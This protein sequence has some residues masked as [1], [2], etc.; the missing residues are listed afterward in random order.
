ME[1]AKK[2]I[3]LSDIDVYFLK[4][5]ETKL[6]W[7]FD[8]NDSGIWEKRENFYNGIRKPERHV[9][10]IDI[11]RPWFYNLFKPKI[12]GEPRSDIYATT[13]YLNCNLRQFNE[14][15]KA[16]YFAKFE[17]ELCLTDAEEQNVTLKK[18]NND[19]ANSIRFL[20]SRINTLESEL[21]ELRAKETIKAQADKKGIQ[22]SGQ[23]SLQDAQEVLFGKRQEK[24][25]EPEPDI[26]EDPEEPLDKFEEKIEEPIT[27]WKAM[28]FAETS[29][30][31]KKLEFVDSQFKTLLV[32][33]TTREIPAERFLDY[34]KQ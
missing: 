7:D 19:Q 31:K 33:I 17:E 8:S 2:K 30:L 1:E 21:E 9:L 29:E 27:N 32:L 25:L 5:E 11:T 28:Y 26:E 3:E 13:L 4:P 20:Q 10:A 15:I 6:L 24:I 12:E 22:V 16:K 23:D 14:W 18:V 34:L